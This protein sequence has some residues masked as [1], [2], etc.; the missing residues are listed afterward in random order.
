MAHV[1]DRHLDVAAHRLRVGAAHRIDH[2]RLA[3]ERHHHV[4][5]ERV[6]FPMAGEPQHAAAKAPMARPARHDDGVELVFAHLCAQRGVAALVFLLG[7]LLV[8]RVAVVRR[9]AHVG[10][11]QRLIELAAHDLPRLRTDA[12]R[13]DVH[14]H[15]G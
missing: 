8:D 1:L 4:A 12:G 6:P 14:V 10:E 11:R 13:G 7:K 3:F 15:D 9:L 2:G 5:G